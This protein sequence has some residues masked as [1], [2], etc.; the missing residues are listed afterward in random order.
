MK[1]LKKVEVVHQVMC[2]I[3]FSGTMDSL[4][5]LEYAEL[6]AFWGYATPE[7]GNK[8]EL[9]FCYSCFKKEIIDHLEKKYDGLK[10]NKHGDDNE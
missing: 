7:D 8:Y 5:N 3:C 4:G 10:L 6:K 9:H 2:D 1:L